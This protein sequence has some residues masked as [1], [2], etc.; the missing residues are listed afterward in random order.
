MEPKRV[1]TGHSAPKF[2]AIWKSEVVRAI[3][4]DGC[5]GGWVCATRTGVHVVSN[6][7]EVFAHL[8]DSTLVGVDMPIGLPTTGVRTSDRHARAFLTKRASTIFSTP[9]RDLIDFVD[10]AVANTTSKERHGRGIAKQAFHL[11]R[12]IRELD[13]MMSPELED[14]VVE[15][16]PECSFR[17]MSGELLPSKHTPLGLAQRRQAIRERFGD[18]PERLRGAKPDDILDAYAVLWS[19]ERFARGEH[20]TLGSTDGDERDERGLVMRIVV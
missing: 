10:Y 18:V 8:D 5:P 13:N 19:T 20:I 4:I 7:A 17:E 2:A 3:G 14:R 11:F 6:L 15:V 12:R 9:P 16:H 1:K